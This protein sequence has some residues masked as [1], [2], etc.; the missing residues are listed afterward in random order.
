MMM[1]TYHPEFRNSIAVDE[2][3]RRISQELGLS[4]KD[5]DYESHENFYL[6][7]ARKVGLEGWELDRLIF[8]FV[9]DIICLLRMGR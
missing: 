7:V 2:R 5:K 9:D 3:L 4:F 8:R 6:D 1:D